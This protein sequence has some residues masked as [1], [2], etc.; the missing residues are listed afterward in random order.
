MIKWSTLENT[1]AVCFWKILLV[2][3]ERQ[4]NSTQVCLNGFPYKS[5]LYGKQLKCAWVAKIVFSYKSFQLSIA[6]GIYNGWKFALSARANKLFQK[7]T[8][9]LLSKVDHIINYCK[10]PISYFHIPNLKNVI[11]NNIACWYSLLY[12]LPTTDNILWERCLQWTAIW[13]NWWTAT[14]VGSV[15][16]VIFNIF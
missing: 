12:L 16:V 5:E 4:L 1:K 3:W 9:F 14:G 8:V 10:R 2:V 13:P 11:I 6:L 7:Q 15:R